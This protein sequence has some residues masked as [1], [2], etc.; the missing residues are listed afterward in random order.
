M[1][2]L[3]FISVFFE[4]SP[5]VT[6]RLLGTIPKHIEK[7]VFD[8]VEQPPNLSPPASPNLFKLS[9]FGAS[10]AWL[11]F[12]A[13]PGQ[14]PNFSMCFGISGVAEDGEAYFY[15][16]KRTKSSRPA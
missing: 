4:M 13:S 16:Y 12:R 10:K 15:E 1:I 11:K 7:L 3:S 8:G 5:L 14:I 2:L 6:R 9:C